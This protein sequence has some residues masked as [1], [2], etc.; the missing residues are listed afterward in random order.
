MVSGLRF[1]GLNYWRI[2]PHTIHRFYASPDAMISEA[3]YNDKYNYVQITHT[4][5]LSTMMLFS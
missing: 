2:S 5:R 4:A 3:H 1:L